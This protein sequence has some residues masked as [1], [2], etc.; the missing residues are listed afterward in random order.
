MHKSNQPI[1]QY[2]NASSPAQAMSE[3]MIANSRALNRY[4]MPQ[5][6]IYCG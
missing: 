6:S 2:A 1:S 3:N 5:K 4:D